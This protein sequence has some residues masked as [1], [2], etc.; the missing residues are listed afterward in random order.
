MVILALSRVSLRAR[1]N[2]SIIQRGVEAG[3]GRDAVNDLIRGTGQRGLR[4]QDIGRAVRVAKGIF[5]DA[6]NFKAVRRDRR[7]DV[8][9]WKV[10]PGKIRDGNQF[11]SDFEVTWVDAHGKEGIPTLTVSTSAAQL[12]RSQ[13]EQ[14]AKDAWEKGRNSDDYQGL[15]F[16][17]A[18]PALRPRRNY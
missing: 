11:V 9:G 15:I 1:E 14:L 6:T 5:D 18:S 10:M 12:L 2:W 17:S 3:L 8:M 16:V 7:P 13:W 4:N